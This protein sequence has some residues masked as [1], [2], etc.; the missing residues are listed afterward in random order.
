MRLISGKKKLRPLEILQT[1]SR[2]LMKFDN[3][4]L[5]G[6]ISLSECAKLVSGSSA[7]LPPFLRSEACFL[8]C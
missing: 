2:P 7:S 1:C 5:S 4:T 8:C 3:R 6:Y